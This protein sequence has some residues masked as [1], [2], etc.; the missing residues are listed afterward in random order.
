MNIEEAI[1]NADCLG[2]DYIALN[3]SIDLKSK[4]ETF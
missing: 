4:K 3:I 2:H 1:T